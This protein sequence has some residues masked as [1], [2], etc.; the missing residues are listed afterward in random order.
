MKGDYREQFNKWINS[1]VLD[2]ASRAELA[3]ISNNEEELK[4]RFGTVPSFGTSGIRG[5]MRAGY[6]GM[7][8]Y[9]VRCASQA[10]AQS[11]I[12]EG[13]ASD[14]VVVSHDS[15]HNSEL[16]AEETAA[17][18]A[19]N[20][21]K[22]FFFDALRP[23]PELSF[24]V[25]D[26]HAVAGVNITASHNPKEYNGYK[27]YWDDASQIGL[28]KANEL[29][30]LL[31]EIRIFEDVRTMSFEDAVGAGHIEIIGAEIDERYLNAVLEQSLAG[32]YVSEYA[33]DVRIVYAAFHGAG[34]KPVQKV[35]ERVGIRNV[36][37]VVEQLIPDGD[38]P[39]VENPN[40]EYLA[41]YDLPI[42][43]AE[44]NNA[45]LIIGTDPDSDRCGAVMKTPEGYKALTG[46]QIGMLLLDYIL[47][48]RTELGTLPA[49]AAVIKSV[50]STSLCERICDAYGVCCVET[51]T[52][53]KF[54]GEKIKEY[55]VSGEHSFIFGFE[56]SIGYLA[57]T[58]TRDKDAVLAAMLLAEMTCYFRSKG[59]SVYEGLLA[60]YD[61]YGYCEEFNSSVRYDGYEAASRM[62]AS[63]LALRNNLPT[64]LGYPVEKVR[65]FSK[66][67]DGFPATDMLNF[68]LTE[69]CE[70]L[71]RPSG[72]EP[73]VKIYVK[74][75]D[76]TA[77]KARIKAEKVMTATKNALE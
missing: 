24:A 59:E 47:T 34:A 68:Y 55:E 22:V 33:D 61:K 38:F 71:I 17:V 49:N 7:N 54:I 77:D 20:G 39:S 40:P 72:T 46:N 5:L 67:V 15:R 8:I 69:D 42:E 65:D 63:M 41:N 58:Y 6:N 50:V 21:V 14:G 73:I 19:A 45:D 53:F 60:L 2:E 27:V 28:D 75:S 29:A 12:S 64:E 25:R 31:D 74:S 9:T 70:V 37:P 51:L 43:Y 52:G 56:E 4:D 36:I 57:G 35:L 30:E 62:S 3:A 11:V 26:L 66:G 13:R 48:R 23:T 76:S 10:L 32:D 1:P 16:F 18:L 44:A